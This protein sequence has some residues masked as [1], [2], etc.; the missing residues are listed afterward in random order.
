MEENNCRAD[1]ICNVCGKENIAVLLNE[2]KNREFQSCRNCGSS[3]RMRSLMLALSKELFGKELILSEFPINKKI[4]GI[5]LSDWCGYAKILEEKF[6]YTN[7][8]YHTD[9]KLDITAISESL[10]GKYDFI[11]SS[12]VYEHIPLY[13]LDSAFKNTRKLLKSNGKFLLTVPFTKSGASQ[14]HFPSLFDFR[15]VKTNGKSFL[16]NVT[17]NGVTEIF[18]GLIFHGGDGSTLEMRIF[19]EPDLLNLLGQAGFTS[20]HICSENMEKFG[21]IWPMDWAV[22]VVAN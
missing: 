18:D 4:K 19:S 7:T 6:S 10:Y 11:I 3:L 8:F 13:C 20:H 15:I 21:I 22:P 5:G 12:D 14:E 1:F 17:Q 9:P 16:L 2:I